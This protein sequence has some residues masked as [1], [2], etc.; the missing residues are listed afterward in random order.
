MFA[1]CSSV[2]EN[3][4]N[5]WEPPTVPPANLPNRIYSMTVWQMASPQVEDGQE[6]QIDSVQ[7]RLSEDQGKG[8][9][10]LV[11]ASKRLFFLFLSWT[12]I[13]TE[14]V[15]QPEPREEKAAECIC[16]WILH[17]IPL[18]MGFMDEVCR[19]LIV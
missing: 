2:L 17:S 12:S 7:G 1:E 11:L 4:H 9:K 6:M 13:T 8:R 19:R 18:L 10:S 15:T 14:R 3:P 5:R 16:I